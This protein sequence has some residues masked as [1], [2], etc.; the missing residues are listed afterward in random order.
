MLTTSALTGSSVVFC[1]WCAP[2]A[3][4]AGDDVAG[5]ELSESVEC[6]QRRPPR[7]HDDHLLVAVVE[8][9]RRA[10]VARIDLVERRT[11][12]LCT[13]L[14]TDASSSPDQRRLGT[15]DPLLRLE[16]VRHAVNL[17]VDSRRSPNIYQGDDEPHGETGA[18]PKLAQSLARSSSCHE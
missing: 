6:P 2:R 12:P 1:S 16:D 14:R 17:T 18:G 9:E 15:L 8:V 4:R 7:D 5:L 11:E 13:R 3:D 10:V